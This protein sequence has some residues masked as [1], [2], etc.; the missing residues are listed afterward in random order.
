M[1]LLAC[2]GP[3]QCQREYRA[4]SCR[5]FP[6]FPYVTEDYQFLGLA[7][8]WEFEDTCWVISNLTQVTSAYRQEFIQTFDDLFSHWMAE[9]EG[10]AAKSEQMRV[11]FAAQK[12]RIPL[13]HRNGGYYLLRPDSE[14]LHRVTPE[15][16]PQFGVYR[17]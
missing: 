7:Y 2:L 8:E 3:D 14:R 10:Y 1:V 5:Q 12:Q 17:D 15:R 16:L 6:F 4:L 11:H 9:M 13:L